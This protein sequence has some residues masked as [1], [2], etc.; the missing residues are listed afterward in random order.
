MNSGLAIWVK[1]ITALNL[2]KSDPVGLKGAVFRVRAGPVRDS[3]INEIRKLAGSITRLHPNMSDEQLFGGVDIVATLQNGNLRTTKGLFERQGWFELT[4]AER[5]GLHTAARISQALDQRQVCPLV[6]FDEGIDDEKLPDS[7]KERLAFYFDLSEL[8]YTDTDFPDIEILSEINKPIKISQTDIQTLV[9]LANEFGISSARAPQL[10]LAAAR[11]NAL[12][13][14]RRKLST[15][16]LEIAVELVYPN[17]AT[18]LPQE[19]S[20]EEAAREQETQP[21][22][23]YDEDSL[24]QDGNDSIELPNELLVDAIRALLPDNFLESL[25]TISPQLKSGGLG[26]GSQTKSKIRGRPQPSRPGR[27][28]GQNRIDIV[29]TLRSAAPLQKIRMQNSSDDRTVIIYPSDI[30]VKRYETRSE[31]VVIF[32]VDASGSAALARLSEAKGAVELLLSQAY[33]RRDFVALIAFRNVDAELLLP[34]T[35]SLVQTKRRLAELPGGGGTPM[36]NGLRAAGELAIKSA[37]KGKTPLIVVLTD[38]RAN[39]TLDGTPDRVLA[40]EQS[41]D[42]AK[43]ISSHGFKSVVLDVGNRSNTALAKVARYMNS[44]YFPL[45]RADA[46]QISETIGAELER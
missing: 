34:P 25:N 21:E 40:L 2:L 38:G 9:L 23:N 6:V 4:M 11:S 5:C 41:C 42:I 20:L 19:S 32:A 26:F 35:R 7:L 8:A 27:L 18:R 22:Q 39:I 16:D 12:T 31:R 10:A 24:K 37:L 15:E 1:V 44:L 13:N 36:A 17:R 29:S 43:W 14:G 46:Q 33:A 3:L 28:D 45:P 30:N